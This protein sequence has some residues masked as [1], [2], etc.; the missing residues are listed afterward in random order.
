MCLYQQW[1]T[2]PQGVREMNCQEVRLLLSEYLDGEIEESARDVV[3]KHLAACEDCSRELE[4]MR[5]AVRMLSS[6]DEIRPPE[7]LLERIEAATVGRPTIG[8]RLK[9]VFAPV[10]AYL[11]WAGASVAVVAI[12]LV[13]ITHHPTTNAPSSATPKVAVTQPTSTVASPAETAPK[14]A[15]A[16]REQSAVSRSRPVVNR[17]VVAHKPVPR[18]AAVKPAS[19][20]SPTDEGSGSPSE[21][22]PS[23]SPSDAET[24]VASAST[25]DAPQEQPK[26]EIKLAKSPSQTDW[27]KR[28]SDALAGV[29][30]KLAE[31][32]KQRR[33]EVRETPIEERQYSFNLASVRF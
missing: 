13:A 16:V 17:V 14:V 12:L 28:E 32:N 7:G 21:V 6:V 3:G 1:T 9:D 10:P 23:A 4:A 22:E 8:S 18:K 33:Y 2:R 29:R 24:P 5:C 30:A 15:A 19:K 26:T 20:P 25:A 11:R 31:R 27:Q